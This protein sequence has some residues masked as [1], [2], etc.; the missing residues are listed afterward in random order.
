LLLLAASL[1][2]SVIQ[3]KHLDTQLTERSSAAEKLRRE[4]AGLKADVGGAL[5][6]TKASID[7]AAKVSKH[8]DL[9][10]PYYAMNLL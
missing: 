4:E 7:K 8:H 9:K 1:A 5:A 2:C 3:A 10:S 6:I